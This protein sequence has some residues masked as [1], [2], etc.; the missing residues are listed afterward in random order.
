[1]TSPDSPHLARPANPS[2]RRLSRGL[3]VGSAAFAIFGIAAVGTF[4]AFPSAPSYRTDFQ[5]MWDT[6]Y[7]S[8]ELIQDGE[9]V[10]GRYK[11]DLAGQ[12]QSG[13]LE[14]SIEQGTLL[15]RWRE[16]RPDRLAHGRGRFVL[17]PDGSRF[18]GDWVDD[19]V[20][21]A[22]PSKWTGVRAGAH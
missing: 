1:M 10:S 21:D 14:G 11:Y 6:D 22:A 5:G 8:L 4:R 13:L 15:F 17:A 3:L 18:A 12:P 7:G 20:A 2:R 9:E 19:G 16:Q